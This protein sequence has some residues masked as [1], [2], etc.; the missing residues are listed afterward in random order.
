M[1]LSVAEPDSPGNLGEDWLEFIIKPW[2]ELEKHSGDNSWFG[3]AIWA[4]VRTDKYAAEIS[5]GHADSADLD[6]LYL[7]YRKGSVET[8]QFEIAAG[9]YSYQL[10]HAAI[11]I[12][13]MGQR[14]RRR[15]VFRLPFRPAGVVSRRG[16]LN[17][18]RPGGQLLP[19][20]GGNGLVEH[21]HGVR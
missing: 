17:G 7:G 19:R 8:G 12:A 5:G 15:V 1:S 9:R 10:A 21:Q 11:E 18:A 4:Y 14:R 13:P 3:K 6:E 2:A 20:L 16:N